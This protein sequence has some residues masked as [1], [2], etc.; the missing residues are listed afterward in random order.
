MGIQCII[1][2]KCLR[3]YQETRSV[4]EGDQ[5]REEAA[6]EETSFPSQRGRRS[7]AYARESA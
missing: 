5:V 7:H 6:Q 1:L 4:I 2:S 3:K